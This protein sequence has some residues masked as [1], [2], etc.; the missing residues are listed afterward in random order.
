[1]ERQPEVLV[2]RQSEAVRH[3]RRRPCQCQ[4][5]QEL[6][7]HVARTSTAPAS[8]VWAVSAA[9]QGQI[10]GRTSARTV[11]QENTDAPLRMRIARCQD[12]KTMTNILTY[13]PYP[14]E[15]CTFSHL[16]WRYPPL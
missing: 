11:L 15:R 16:I 13:N 8:V 1:V 2:E 12:A 14:S 5:Q 9:V 4:L 10:A 3:L 6:P 7:P